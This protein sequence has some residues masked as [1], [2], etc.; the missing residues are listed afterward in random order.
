MPA[1]HRKLALD[2]VMNPERW[3]Q[4]DQLFHSALE[5]DP[6]ARAAFLAQACTGDEALRLEVE[7]LIGSHEQ[8][9]SFIEAPA[10]DLAAEL[11]AGKESE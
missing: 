2:H 6:G 7:S 1:L 10:A 11:L 5:R 8:S 4:I 9:D 3:Q